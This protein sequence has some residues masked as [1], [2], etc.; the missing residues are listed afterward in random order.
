MLAPRARRLQERVEQADAEGLLAEEHE[1]LEERAEG[2]GHARG[3]GRGCWEGRVVGG[4]AG[5]GVDEAGERLAKWVFKELTLV[6]GAQIVREQQQK[7]RRA[8]SE[9]FAHGVGLIVKY[10]PHDA[11]RQRENNRREVGDGVEG[12]AWRGAEARGVVC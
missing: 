1:R 8:F 7:Q 11:Q 5:G 4:D 6:D 9:R 3:E 12:L 10:V 2:H